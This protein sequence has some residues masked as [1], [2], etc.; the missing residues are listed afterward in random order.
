MAQLITFGEPMIRLSPPDFERLEQSTVLNLRVGGSEMNVAVVAQ[1]LGV[2]SS[3]VTR[4]PENSLGYLVRN[5]VREQ[6]VDTSHIIWADQSRCGLYFVEFGAQP[7]ASSVLYDRKHSAISEVRSGDFQWKNIFSGAQIYHTSGITPALSPSAA[8]V[9]IE[10]LKAAKAAGLTI[11]LDLNYRARLWPEEQAQAVITPMMEYVDILFTTEEDTY[12]VFKIRG[13][14]YEDIA[15]ALSEQ[16]QLQIVAVT[17]R[18]NLSVWRNKWSGIAC[19]GQTIYT[20]ATYDLEIVDRV[21]AGDSFTGGFLYGYMTTDGDIQR[22]LDYATAVSALK[23]SIPGDF[24]WTIRSE[25]EKLIEGK[26]TLR[27][28]R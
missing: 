8:S 28:S 3:F 6:G 14:N 24:N 20:S 13:N 5:K 2:E 25:V 22:A 11:S 1:R 12:R 7:R 17:L 15:S 21:G 18:E 19:A 16:F 23:H 10:S 26:G 9:T 27:I 4:L